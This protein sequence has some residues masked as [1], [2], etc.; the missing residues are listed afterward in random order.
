M[1]AVLCSNDEN[2]ADIQGQIFGCNKGLGGW[3]LGSEHRI[4]KDV[5]F[6]CII[7][8]YIYKR[9][10]LWQMFICYETHI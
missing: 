9:I 2:V 1:P 4:F 5:Q 6:E 3:L 7:S 10:M 8:I